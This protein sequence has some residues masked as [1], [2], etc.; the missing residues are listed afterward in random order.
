MRHFT[1]F[2]LIEPVISYLCFLFGPSTDV[3]CIASKVVSLFHLDSCVV[4][5]EILKLK[6]NTAI[7][8]RATLGMKCAA[9][10][11][12]TQLQ[13]MKIELGSNFCISLFF[14][15][16]KLIKSKSRPVM[17]HDQLLIC[18]QTASVL[19]LH[20]RE[21][22][23]IIYQLLVFCRSSQTGLTCFIRG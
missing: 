2:A 18:L 17:T 10:T 6:N 9:G 22:S 3:D 14:C 11:E 19:K 7:N 13:K 12:V 21:M 20:L 1:D 16:M 8:S 5:N 4:E 23:S 15:D